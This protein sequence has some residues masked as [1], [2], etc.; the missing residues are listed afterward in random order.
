MYF[1]RRDLIVAATSLPVLAL[2]A[3][4]QA[5]VPRIFM[6]DGL[7]LGGNDAVAYARGQGPVPG[8]AENTLEWRGARWRF[9]DEQS[10]ATF[11]MNPGAYAPRFGGYCAFALSQGRL[12]GGDPAFWRIWEGRLYLM[13]GKSERD[14]WLRDIPAAIAAAEARWPAILSN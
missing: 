11:V 6:I 14:Q 7:A 5:A 10:L 13:H 12:Q 3:A 8:L 4:V 1:S 9:A 2:P